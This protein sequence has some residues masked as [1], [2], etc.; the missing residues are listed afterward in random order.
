MS[1]PGRYSGRI[2]CWWPPSCNAREESH[3]PR[4]LAKFLEQSLISCLLCTAPA[5]KMPNYTTKRAPPG[6]EPQQHR[7]KTSTAS[8]PQPSV[9]P[10]PIHHTTECSSTCRG[11]SLYSHTP[12]PPNRAAAPPG[13]FSCTV[14]ARGTTGR[15]FSHCPLRSSATQNPIHLLTKQLLKAVK[16]PQRVSKTLVQ[17]QWLLRSWQRQTGTVTA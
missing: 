9:F 8:P 1:I 6:W 11:S 5:S 14:G 4:E 2:K 3:I 13:R 10:I 17:T 12:L 7:T 15:L 16:F